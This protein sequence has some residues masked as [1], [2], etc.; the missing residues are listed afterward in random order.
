MRTAIASQ[1]LL[2]KD[3]ELEGLSIETGRVTFSVASREPRSRC[4]LCGHSSSRVHS[5][6]FRA[7]SDLPWHGVSMVLKVHARRFFCDEAACG[8]PLQGSRRTPTS[9]TLHSHSKRPRPVCY[10]PYL[11]ERWNEGC[12]NGKRLLG[13]IRER[14]Y[15]GSERTFVRFTG[16]LRRAEAAG[17]PPSLAPRARRGLVA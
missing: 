16:E 15:P 13:E 17:K 2:P 3:F 9:P 11:L 12:H 7:V 8:L 6:Y 10:V 4:H 5:W 1:E 14:G